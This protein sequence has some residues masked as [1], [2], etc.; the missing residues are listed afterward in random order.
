MS[1]TRAQFAKLLGITVEALRYYEECGILNV[2]YNEEGKRYQYQEADMVS[3]MNIRLFRALNVPVASIRDFMTGHYEEPQ[4]SLLDQQIESARLQIKY[5]VELQDQMIAMQKRNR[6]A[7]SRLNSVIEEERPDVYFLPLPHD[8]SQK[9]HLSQMQEWMDALPFTWTSIIIPPADWQTEEAFIRATPALSISREYAGKYLSGYPDYAL[10]KPGAL[11]YKT[12][13][14]T[15]DLSRISR[16]AV[17]R[18]REY[19]GQKGTRLTGI[20][21]GILLDQVWQE[22]HFVYYVGITADFEK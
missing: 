22:D 11:N 21:T 3:V 4:A 16:E 10:Y 7:V 18:L 17:D 1:Y 20:F 9:Q 5:L 6:S 15:D 13:T 19:A 12:V 2:K 8:F 14:A